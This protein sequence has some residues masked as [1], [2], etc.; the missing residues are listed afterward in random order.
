MEE[1]AQVMVAAE[2]M[3]QQSGQT[4]AAV[5]AEVDRRFASK[6]AELYGEDFQPFHSSAWPAPC[7]NAGSAA[8]TST[9]C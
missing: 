6:L 2:A 3:L 1:A 4:L 9:Q 5:E 8:A 7:R